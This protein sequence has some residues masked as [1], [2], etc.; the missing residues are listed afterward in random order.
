MKKENQDKK[1]II[2]YMPSAVIAMASALTA[3]QHKA[4]DSMLYNAK[5][6]LNKNQNAE[7]FEITLSE[8]KYLAGHAGGN[9]R[10]KDSIEKLMATTG[11]FNIFGKDRAPWAYK[12]VLLSGYGVKYSSGELTIVY[13][14]DPQIRKKLAD[15]LY[16]YSKIDLLTRKKLKSKYAIILYRI[17]RD[18]KDMQI[19]KIPIEKFKFLCGIAALYDGNIPML[20]RNV[21]DVACAEINENTDFKISYEIIEDF[22]KFKFKAPVTQLPEKRTSKG[23]ENPY[24]DPKRTVIDNVMGRIYITGGPAE[25]ARQ[26]NVKAPMKTPSVSKEE[27]E[28]ILAG[29]DLSRLPVEHIKKIKERYNL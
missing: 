10:I 24:S 9:K 3:F 17:L 14:F 26:E 5:K 4:W 23:P 2:L 21:L 7:T 18:Y 25:P 16:I 13:S 19:P 28:R 12:A 20:K 1:E 8:L 6:T 22:I 15:N 29:I 27:A 11:V